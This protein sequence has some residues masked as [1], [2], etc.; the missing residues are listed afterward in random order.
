MYDSNFDQQISVLELIG[1]PFESPLQYHSCLFPYSGT[2]CLGSPSTSLGTSTEGFDTLSRLFRVWSTTM[3]IRGHF[4]PAFS[5]GSIDCLPRGHRL[6][7]LRR[8]RR[9]AHAAAA[10]RHHHWWHRHGNRKWNNHAGSG[11]R[12]NYDSDWNAAGGHYGERSARDRVVRN[13]NVDRHH[14]GLVLRV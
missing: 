1:S 11:L 14:P 12:R 6:L 2:S 3:A 5:M 8:H 10:G 4:L 7:L 13:G 9:E